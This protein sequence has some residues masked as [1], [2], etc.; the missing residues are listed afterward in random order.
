MA[1]TGIED[2]LWYEYKEGE[3]EGWLSE[4]LGSEHPMQKQ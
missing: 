3:K 4:D 1:S 2:E